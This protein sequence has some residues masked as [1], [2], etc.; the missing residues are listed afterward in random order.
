[1]SFIGNNVIESDECSAIKVAHALIKLLRDAPEVKQVT[2]I[3]A[4]HLPM[5]QQD[6]VV[7]AAASGGQIPSAL[8]SCK[9]VAGDFHPRKDTSTRHSKLH[10]CCCILF[11]LSSPC[12]A[13]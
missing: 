7:V 11:G 8:Q 6:S 10:P 4:A 5:C 9:T 13:N 12:M 3:G 1:M 2:L